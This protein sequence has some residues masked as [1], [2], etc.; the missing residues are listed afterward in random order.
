MGKTRESNTCLSRN[1][2]ECQFILEG[3]FNDR[4]MKTLPCDFWA[5]GSFETHSAE[6]R[7]PI[8][9][10][11]VMNEVDWVLMSVLNSWET[12]IQLVQ[13]Q[14]WGWDIFFSAKGSHE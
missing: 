13:T 5:K 1:G 2:Q 14:I 10:N 4:Q 6:D 12:L 8:G 7:Y 9:A 3:V 11:P